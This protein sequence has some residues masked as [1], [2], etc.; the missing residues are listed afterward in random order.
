M[1]RR[2][3]DLGLTPG[4]IVEAWNAEYTPEESARILSLA[5]DMDQERQPTGE[6]GVVPAN[7]LTYREIAQA[8]QEALIGRSY[9]EDAAVR[10]YS[11]RFDDPEG[12]LKL[13][14]GGYFGKRI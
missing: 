5:A 14:G 8:G 11:E 12:K 4:L 13:V 9:L 3:Q 6:L 2:N 10:V 7:R 1:S